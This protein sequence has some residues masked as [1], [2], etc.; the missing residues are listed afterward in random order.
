M[1][2]KKSLTTTTSMFSEPVEEIIEEEILEEKAVVA[3]GGN[4]TRKGRIKG[5]WT[6]YWG[7]SIFNFE[8]GK[9]YTIPNALYDYLKENGNIY[10]TL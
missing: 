7:N 6:M 10:D 4:G 5:T 2:S 9:T 8:D 3:P 1:A